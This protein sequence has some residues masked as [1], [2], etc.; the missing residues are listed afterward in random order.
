MLKVRKG[1]VAYP[2]VTTL[3][4]ASERCNGRVTYLPMTPA[5]KKRTGRYHVALNGFAGKEF[6]GTRLNICPSTYLS[7]TCT[8]MIGIDFTVSPETG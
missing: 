3:T 1:R 5:T 6:S 8:D 4:G 2:P 7:L